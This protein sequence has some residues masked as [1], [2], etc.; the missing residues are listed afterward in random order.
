M[1]KV[2]SLR[3][4][5]KSQEP[6]RSISYF[7]DIQRIGGQEETRETRFHNSSTSPKTP[8]GTTTETGKQVV[9]ISSGNDCSFVGLIQVVSWGPLSFL[10]WQCL[11]DL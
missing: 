3:G 1:V 2:H 7:K 8:I 11:Q 9:A 10:H 5:H 6:C 4:G